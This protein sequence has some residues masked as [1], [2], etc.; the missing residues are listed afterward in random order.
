[1]TRPNKA[2]G[3]ILRETPVDNFSNSVDISGLR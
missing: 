1:L 3:K 2:A